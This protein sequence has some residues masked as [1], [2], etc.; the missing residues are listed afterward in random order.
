MRLEK[1]VC[2]KALPARL[3]D[4]PLLTTERIRCPECHF[5]DL[6]SDL[7]PFSDAGVAYLMRDLE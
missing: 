7:L 1:V 4:D 6:T 5:E 3:D 2:S